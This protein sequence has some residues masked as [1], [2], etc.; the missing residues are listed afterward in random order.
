MR[1]ILARL[2]CAAAAVLSCAAAQA[3]E[4]SVAVAANF[5]APMQKI[6]AVFERDTGHKARLA[7]GATGK[8]YAQ[9]R[10]GAPFELFLS[11]DDTT[12][13]KLEEDG[14]AV[15]G[16]RFTYAIGKLVLWSAQA[17][18]VD[19]QGEVLKR[20]AFA[21]LAVANPKTAPYGAAA[22]EVLRKLGV[23]EALAPKLVTGENIA[24]THQFVATGNA[25][26]GFV[27]LSQVWAEGRLSG[28]SAWLVP[29]ELHAPLR[30]DAVIL[31]KGRDNPAARALVEYLRG[32]KAAAIIK[33]YGYGQ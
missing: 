24:Q 26:L 23:A 27:A 19:D 10:N 14:S 28:G 15:A 18:V 33:S 1:A 22:L 20:G 4:V 32:A 16:S 13:A 6:A 8:F 31:A 3:A 2:L 30:Q 11:A 5:T 25:E 29:A 7:F 9:I 17:G 21:H 12:P